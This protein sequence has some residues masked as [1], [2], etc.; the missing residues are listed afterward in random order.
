VPAIQLHQP[1]VIDPADT[2]IGNKE[3]PQ[4]GTFLGYVGQGMARVMLQDGT[5]TRVS[6]QRVR[7]F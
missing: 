5:V 6:V 2:S 3:R 1:I 7:T 4:F